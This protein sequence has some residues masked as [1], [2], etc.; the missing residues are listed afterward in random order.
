MEIAFMDT[1]VKQ[2]DRMYHYLTVYCSFQEETLNLLTYKNLKRLA[3]DYGFN[4]VR[5]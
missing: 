1:Y 5:G 2:K 4:G 3:S